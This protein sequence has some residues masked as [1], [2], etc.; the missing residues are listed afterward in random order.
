MSFW[1]QEIDSTVLFITQNNVTEGVTNNFWWTNIPNLLMTWL[2][3]FQ[4]SCIRKNQ[5]ITTIVNY[6]LITQMS[7]LPFC[8]I[9]YGDV[10]SLVCQSMTYSWMTSPVNVTCLTRHRLCDFGWQVSVSVS[11]RVTNR[12][13]SFVWQI[14]HGP[15]G[16]VLNTMDSESDGDRQEIY[17]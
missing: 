10:N 2:E 9:I 13:P 16:S 3:R 12:L 17:Q 4:R 14:S 15:S 6:P 7:V 8:L 11:S 5:K 1:S